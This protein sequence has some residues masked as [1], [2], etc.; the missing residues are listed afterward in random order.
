MHLEMIDNNWS[1]ILRNRNVANVS[2]SEFN[3]TLLER[4][5]RFHKHPRPNKVYNILWIMVYRFI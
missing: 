3:W 4:N 5:W 2:G 1:T